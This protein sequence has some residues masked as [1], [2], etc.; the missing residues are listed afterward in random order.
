M[1]LAAHLGHDPAASAPGN[2]ANGPSLETLAVAEDHQ[3]WLART[4]V[5]LTPIAAPSIMGLFGFFIAALMVGAWQ[6]QWFGPA[7][8]TSI[9][10]PFVV[11][12]GAMQLVAA[13]V[14]FRARDGVA[15]AVHT[16]WGAFWLG[17]SLLQAL[18]ASG[19]VAAIAVGAYNPAYAFWFIALTCITALCMFAA[20]GQ[21]L[22]LTTMLGFLSLASVLTAIGFYVGDAVI[23]NAG[24]WLFVCS[25][26]VAL[27]TAGAM[28]FEHSYGRTIIPRSKWSKQAAIPG[29]P[30]TDP[31]AYP[32]GMPGLKVGQ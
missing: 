20:F 32:A 22:L 28:M 27:A 30:A 31:I 1:R 5:N 13:I 3:A 11:F 19:I 15:V 4:R 16:V 18:I 2:H 10:W 17:W 14:A 12:A 25:A 23:D 7:N 26:V 24:G 29:Q 8:A 9:L 21:N 6:A